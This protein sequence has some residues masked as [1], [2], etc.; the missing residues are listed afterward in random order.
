MLE[1]EAGRTRPDDQRERSQSL[2]LVLLL[3]ATA[4]STDAIGFLGLNGLFTA[5]ITGNIVILAAH[6]VA[7][8]RAAIAQLIAVPVFMAVLAL[9]RLLGLALDRRG[10]GAAG[11]TLLVIQFAF[12]LGFLLLCLPLGRSFDA[13]APWVVLAGMC[14]V[15]A[16]A[17]QNGLVQIVMPGAPSTAVLTTNVTR[18]T[19][20]AVESVAGPATGRGAA[21]E[22]VAANF[23]PIIGFLIGCAAG[24]FLQW[25]IGL[26]ALVLPAALGLIAILVDARRA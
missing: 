3:S 10:K 8:G 16:M 11:M 1:R 2:A 5:H 19:V 20:A 17:V 23:R 6:L 25:Q 26:I 7:H 18:F 15:A 12:L 24:A 22:K 14:G 4:G 13:D 21:R 9:A